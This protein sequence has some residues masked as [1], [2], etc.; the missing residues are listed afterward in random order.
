MTQPELIA[1]TRCEVGENP[2][3]HPGEESV[4]WT[5]IPNGHLYRYNPEK[6]DHERVYD[7]RPVGGFTIQADGS[8]L[9]FKNRGTITMWN[10]D[11]ETTVV[12]NIEREQD[13]R[14]NDVQADPLGRVFAGTMP[15]DSRRG[16]L[17]R[18]HRDATVTQI[19]DDFDIPNGM[20]FSLDLTTL[21]MTESN[22]HT[23]YAYT[24][25]AE[26]GSLSDRT[27]FIQTEPDDGI[28]DGLTIDN[29]GYLWSARWDGGCIVRYSPDG[30]EVDRI[31]FP[32]DKVS[33]PSFGDGRTLYVTTA[34][35]D[36]DDYENDAGGLFQVE[37]PVF[38][39]GAFRSRVD[40]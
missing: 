12:E 19:D 21:Y 32:A 9:L 40:M 33:C 10:D 35:D 11:E 13:S 34:K 15:N 38:S 2:I 20:A 30:T 26:S 28:P 16:A 31:H 3:Y 7:G 1:D 29:E 8:L 24:Y 4:Y 23:I 5:D 18:I 36:G 27:R 37:L 39:S 6:G 17:Y 22:A 25:E 14:F